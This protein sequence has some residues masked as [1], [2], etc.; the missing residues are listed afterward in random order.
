MFKRLA[1]L[2]IVATLPSIVMADRYG[3]Y[4]PDLEGYTSTSVI[5]MSIYIIAMMWA[6]LT[7]SGPLKPWADANPN[8]SLILFLFVAP[9]L[10][11]FI[12]SQ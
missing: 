5:P 3:M 10:I 12:F 9:L 11:A 7:D 6:T 4:D 1:F 2:Y 8:K